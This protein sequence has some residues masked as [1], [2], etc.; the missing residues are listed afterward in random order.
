MNK[1]MKKKINLIAILV[2]SGVLMLTVTLVKKN[3]ENRSQA[4]YGTVAMSFLPSEGKVQIGKRLISTV[5]L[6]MDSYLLTGADLRIKYDQDKL[7]LRSVSVMTDKTLKKGNPWLSSS[8]ELVLSNK[9]EAA[10]TATVVGANLQKKLRGLPS[11]A[12]VMMKLIFVGKAVGEANV[13][14]DNTYENTV[15]GYNSSGTDQ[16]L[17]IGSVNEATYTVEEATK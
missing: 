17:E 6:N 9:D 14:L 5:I 15:V 1:N 11:G 12:V 3:Q 4:A 2:L 10:G 13:T 7:T 16:E 8:Q